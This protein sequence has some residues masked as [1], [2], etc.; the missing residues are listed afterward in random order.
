MDIKIGDKVAGI[1]FDVSNYS[2]RQYVEWGYVFYVDDEKV[3][4]ARYQKSPE[5]VKINSETE[6]IYFVNSETKIRMKTLV[7]NIISDLRENIRKLTAEEKDELVKTEFEQ[8]KQKI[9]NTASNMINSENESQYINRLKEIC[10]MKEQL[11]SIKISDLNN[12]HMKNG[13]IM[14]KIKQLQEL[15]KNID[16]DNFE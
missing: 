16:Q 12:I 5:Y 7:E 8:I 14:Y 13:A 3:G 9:T 2:S 4:F 15:L 1:K 6:K 10:K 11:F